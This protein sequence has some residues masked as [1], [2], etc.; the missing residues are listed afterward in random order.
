MDDAPRRMPLLDQSIRRAF[1]Q[2][3]DFG[4][5]RS[6]ALARLARRWDCTPAEVEARACREPKP[7]GRTPA[8]KPF[9]P[10]P[11]YDREQ[12]VIEC[13]GLTGEALQAKY[14]ELATRYKVK[15]QT[16]ASTNRQQ[17]PLTRDPT[18]EEIEA[19]L[20]GL[21]ANWTDRDRYNRAK[22]AT[23]RACD[24]QEIKHCGCVDGRL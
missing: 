17:Q 3:C 22:Y 12:I 8:A 4:Y 13:E 6:E 10:R 24:F 16:I 9:Q 1:D 11:D 18:P 15:P 21:Q 14:R 7:K 20:S 23:P 5:T 2:E 19:H